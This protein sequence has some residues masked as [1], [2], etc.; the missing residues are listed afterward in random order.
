[1]KVGWLGMKVGWLGMKVG[2]GKARRLVDRG[3]ATT[4]CE[5]VD[6]WG[7]PGGRNRFS[8]ARSSTA[9]ASGSVVRTQSRPGAERRASD[10]DMKQS[11]YSLCWS[12][13]AEIDP[14]HSSSP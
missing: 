9:F 8:I 7:E 13:L 11:A 4:L 14:N 5:A 2:A 3:P 6:V 12:P 1:M 10:I